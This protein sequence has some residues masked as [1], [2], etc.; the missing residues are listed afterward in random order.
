MFETDL[1]ALYLKE[2]HN[3]IYLAKLCVLGIRAVRGGEEE[4]ALIFLSHREILQKVILDTIDLPN[5]ELLRRLL[6]WM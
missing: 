1:E 2:L 6:K 5:L 3:N 4:L